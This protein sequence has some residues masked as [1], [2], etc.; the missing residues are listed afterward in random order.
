MFSTAAASP[1]FAAHLH[2]AFGLEPGYSTRDAQPTCTPPLPKCSCFS[3]AGSRAQMRWLPGAYDG[4]THSARFSKPLAP[5][6]LPAL[7]LRNVALQP[8]LI[9]QR[10]GMPERLGVGGCTSVKCSPTHNWSGIR[11]SR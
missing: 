11:P 10:A 2:L 3:D 5:A 6:P 9:C 8:C 1:A 7:S 4:S